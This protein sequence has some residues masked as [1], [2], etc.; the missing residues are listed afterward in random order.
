M[1]DVKHIDIKEFREEGFLQEV[2][3]LVLHPAG[4]ALEV[5][6]EEDGSEHISGVWDYRDDP[7]GMMFGWSEWDEQ[8]LRDNDTH[9][10]HQRVT[11]EINRHREA[12]EKLFAELYPA[13]YRP[14]SIIEPLPTEN[15]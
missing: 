15:K 10:K 7:E 13:P 14:V 1:S 5:T 8:G 6:V 3:R 12:R 2:N 11:A 4:L 9:G